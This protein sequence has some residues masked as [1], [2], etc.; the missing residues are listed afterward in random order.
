[1]IGSVRTRLESSDNLTRAAF[2][3]VLQRIV[4]VILSLVDWIRWVGNYMGLEL[5]NV[6]V[7]Q[8][9]TY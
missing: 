3:N 8:A 1:M 7:N 6:L 4:V 9:V 5:R 2:N